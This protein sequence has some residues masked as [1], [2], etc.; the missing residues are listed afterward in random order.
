M[1]ITTNANPTV[2]LRLV[3]AATLVGHKAQP[4]FDVSA[5]PN[6]EAKLHS[7]VGGYGLIILTPE[8]AADLLLS[9]R[10][11]RI[12]DDADFVQAVRSA[13]AERALQGR[14]PDGEGK[15]WDGETVER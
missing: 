6:G 15:N 4:G 14:G 9:N 3:G 10:P 2:V 1:M 11:V 8:A 5:Q 13:M 7:C 12:P